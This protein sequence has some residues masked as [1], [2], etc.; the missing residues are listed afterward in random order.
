MLCCL[1]HLDSLLH[2]GVK[3]CYIFYSPFLSSSPGCVLY[4]IAF[5]LVELVHVLTKGLCDLFSH[6][7]L[8]YLVYAAG[9]LIVMVLLCWL[10]QICAAERGEQPKWWEKNAGPNMIDIHST[11][12]FLDALR[13]AGDRLVIV[14]FYGTWCGSCRALFPRVMPL[15]VNITTGCLIGS[16][17]LQ[18]YNSTLLPSD[19]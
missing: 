14:E 7:G 17:W 16:V 6:T 13:D 3:Q 10:F 2:F 1:F 8:C 11:V 4:S 19:F 18:L 15:I 12:E 5:L 9:H